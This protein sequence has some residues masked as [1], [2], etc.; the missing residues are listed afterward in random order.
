MQDYVR[1]TNQ[2]LSL[3][4]TTTRIVDWHYGTGNFVVQ[5]SDYNR[6]KVADELSLALGTPCATLTVEDLAAE[7]GVAK[8]TMSPLAQPGFRW[9]RGIAFWADGK[10][11]TIIL[12]PT[13]HAVFF[14]INK[15][16][17]GAFKKDKLAE[18]KETLDAEN[19]AGGW[20]AIS[21]DVAKA[22]GGTWTSR[23]LDR[24]EGVLAKA[25]RSSL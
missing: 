14:P 21:V 10:P 13:I 20:G 4:K 15:H 18:G 17:V 7:V 12:K 19:R 2:K 22:V 9:T 6:M 23:S 5:E 11:C 8:K 25:R 24:I 3:L 16:A 1:A